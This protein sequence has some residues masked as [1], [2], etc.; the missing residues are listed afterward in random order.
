MTAF[1]SIFSD[2]FMEHCSHP[3]IVNMARFIRIRKRLMLK[4]N[5]WNPHGLCLEGLSFLIRIVS[6][7]KDSNIIK[8]IE[9]KMII[10]IYFMGGETL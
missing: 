4:K 2:L 8:P 5:V 6:R 3:K 1:R 7:S 9:L 10:W